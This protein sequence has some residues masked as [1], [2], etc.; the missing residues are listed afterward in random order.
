MAKI[1]A[2]VTSVRDGVAGGAPIFLVNGREELETTAFRLEKL[3]DCAAHEISDTLY[4]LVDRSG[5]NG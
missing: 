5:G 2:I 4:L 1:A 3:L